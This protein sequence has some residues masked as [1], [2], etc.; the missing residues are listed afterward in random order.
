MIF[1]FSQKS[2]IL[3]RENIS[4]TEGCPEVLLVQTGSDRF[5]PVQTP[6]RLIQFDTQLTDFDWINQSLVRHQR[7]NYELDQAVDW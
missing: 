2:F 6:L 5:R 3:K 1:E 7:L 4:S